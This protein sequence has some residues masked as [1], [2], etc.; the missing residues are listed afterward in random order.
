[1]SSD[2]WLPRQW[3]EVVYCPTCHS[4]VKLSVLRMLMGSVY[5]SVLHFSS[6]THWG[7]SSGKLFPR[8][9]VALMQQFNFQ[10]LSHCWTCQRL[11][12]AKSDFVFSSRNSDCE[13][14]NDF[15]LW[16]W[17]CCVSFF[18]SIVVAHWRA[19]YKLEKLHVICVLVERAVRLMFS[20]EWKWNWIG[21]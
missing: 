17:H 7:S 6:P 18:K 2:I 3:S 1:M 14:M 9:L 10:F 16:L 12:I 5:T 21:C 20:Y 13:W 4:I 15:V 11:S 19:L 8:T